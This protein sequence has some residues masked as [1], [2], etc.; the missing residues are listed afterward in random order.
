MIEDKKKRTHIQIYIYIYVYACV[1][2]DQNV[3]FALVGI[4][5]TK[6]MITIKQKVSYRMPF[7]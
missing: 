2:V 5:Y 7:K 4:K 1:Y 6:R 3:F